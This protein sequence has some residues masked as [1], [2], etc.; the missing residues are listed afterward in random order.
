M[1]KRHLALE[2]EGAGVVQAPCGRKDVELDHQG[3]PLDWGSAEI[4]RI[5]RTLGGESLK[6]LVDPYAL[7]STLNLRQTGGGAPASDRQKVSDERHS[8]QPHFNLPDREAA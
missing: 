6:G 4:S 5:V 3:R 7:V 2:C 1:E 8:I